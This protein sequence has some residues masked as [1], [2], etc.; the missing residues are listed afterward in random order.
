M[1]I[2]PA[3]EVV[4]VGAKDHHAGLLQRDLQLVVQE[5]LS[6]TLLEPQF[7]GEPETGI[8]GLHQDRRVQF[9]RI[10]SAHVSEEAGYSIITPDTVLYL[11]R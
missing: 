9:V 5:D 3:G 2:T 10:N 8:Y 4:A 6:H 11:R 7:L 1:I